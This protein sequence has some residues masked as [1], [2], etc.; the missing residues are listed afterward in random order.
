MA[1]RMKDTTSPRRPDGPGSG[2]GRP[3]VEM[4]GI[5]KSFSGVPV[6]RGVDFE[7]RAGRVHALAGGNGAGKSTLMKIL[8]GVYSMDA[9]GIRI[10]GEPVR[11]SSL[12]DARAAPAGGGMV[13]KEVSLAP[14]LPVAQN[15]FLAAEPMGPL[16][17]I[18]DR[19]A[20]RRTREEFAGMHVEV[21]AT[22]RVQ[23]L[24][25]A[26]W[27]MTEIAKALAQD[28]R[29]LIMDEPTASLARHET[30]ALFELVERLKARGIAIIY[31]SHR[32][33]EVYRIADR[34]TILRDGGRL[35]TRSLTEVT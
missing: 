34:I 22:A 5:Y 3:A 23:D 14:T 35:F 13:F 32:M 17:M 18:N 1:E 30:E 31:I 33:D 21:D 7:V 28:A 12:H 9:G 6:L 29:I 24:S 2:D 25:T 19:E 8:Q 16:G 26:Y 10:D 15:V 20:V 4:S 11:L 27:Q